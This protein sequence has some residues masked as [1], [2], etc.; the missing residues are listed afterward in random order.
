MTK[1]LSIAPPAGTAAPTPPT[2][3]SITAG[4]GSATVNF[5]VPTGNGGSAIVAYTATCTASH[6]TTKTVAGAGSALTLR[7]LKGGVSYTC[8]VTASNAYYTSAA[9]N[10][11]MVKPQAGVTLTPIL[12][13]LLD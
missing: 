2:I 4:R 12:M 1:N 9:S 7:G 13:L 6:Q 5:A 10:E 3:S 11:Q 8:T